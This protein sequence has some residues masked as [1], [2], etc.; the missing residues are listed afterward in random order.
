MRQT[1]VIFPFSLNTS[2]QTHLDS[3]KL[4][5][6]Q[7]AML[8]HSFNSQKQQS[9][10]MPVLHQPSTFSIQHTYLPYSRYAFCAF[11]ICFSLSKLNKISSHSW[12]VKNETLL[13]GDTR[14]FQQ[15]MTLLDTNTSSSLVLLSCFHVKDTSD[16]YQ[17]WG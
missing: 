4:S 12:K 16:Y 10:F 2:M 14:V 3:S 15:Q 17:N 6:T 9:F 13:L 5:I 11:S 8:N 7:F 1:E